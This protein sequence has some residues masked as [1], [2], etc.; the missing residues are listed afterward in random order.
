MRAV[1]HGAAA[2]WVGKAVPRREDGALLTGR[3]RF[4]DDLEPVAGLRHAAIL[5]S[6]HPHARIRSIDTSAAEKLSG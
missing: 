1:M 6:P 5:R 3:A 2:G 4:I